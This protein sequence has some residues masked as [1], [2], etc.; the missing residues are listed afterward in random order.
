MVKKEVLELIKNFMR[1]PEKK[2]A[3]IFEMI[4][5]LTCI[6]MGGEGNAPDFVNMADISRM[7]RAGNSGAKHAG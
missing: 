5:R 2:Q 1:L 7:K 4:E 3:E 6:Q